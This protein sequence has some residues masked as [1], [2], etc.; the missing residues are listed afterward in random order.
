LTNRNAGRLQSNSRRVSEP[1]LRWGL[2]EAVEV[3][4][5]PI[6]TLMYFLVTPMHA[7]YCKS[8]YCKRLPTLG[9]V[10]TAL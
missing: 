8:A 5:Y 9:I 6:R 3:A 1:E 4:R 2:L 10:T 7:I